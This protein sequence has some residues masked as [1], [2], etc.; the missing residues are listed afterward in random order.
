ML[1]ALIA[2]VGFVVSATAAFGHHSFAAEFDADQPITVT[3]TVTKV[4]WTNPHARFYMDVKDET[5]QVVNWDFELGGATQLIRRG[6]SR[7]TLKPGEI[8]TVS[9]FRARNAPQVG[10]AREVRLADG[11][12]VL[13]GSSIDPQQ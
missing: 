8:V 2:G 6:W 4:E 5:G 12:R 9:G 1:K 7:T 11:R 13:A 3:G 10:N